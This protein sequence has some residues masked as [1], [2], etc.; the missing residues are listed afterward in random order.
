MTDATYQGWKNYAT[1]GVALVLDNDEGTYNE[2][3]E[4][5]TLLRDAAD[6]DP[7][8]TQGIW[9]AADCVRFRLEDWL[10]DY[11]EELCGLDGDLG[12]PEPTLMARQVLHAGLAEVDWTEVAN[13]YI[14]A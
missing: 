5:V 14:E 6:S 8:V 13:H 1:W 10:K 12:I 3:H 7:N 2:V 9:T 4:Q 11:V